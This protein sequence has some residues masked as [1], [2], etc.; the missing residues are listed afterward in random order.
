M[1]TINTPYSIKAPAGW[2]AITAY[3]RGKEKPDTSV[4]AEKIFDDLIENIKLE[5]C[6]YFPDVVNAM[7]RRLPLKVEAENYGHDGFKNSFFVK[8]TASKSTYYRKKEPVQVKVFGN[9]NSEQAIELV[10]GEWTSYKV[11]SPVQKNFAIVLRA[12]A[13]ESPAEVSISINGKKTKL[14]IAAT[15][16][17]EVIIEKA[18]FVAGENQLQLLVNKGTVQADWMDI[19]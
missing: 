7:F 19:R 12:K 16:W 15:E 13:I 18:I 1:E 5:K 14:S 9:N 11:N 2:E 4:N 6:V 3:S 17:T 10:T 8:D